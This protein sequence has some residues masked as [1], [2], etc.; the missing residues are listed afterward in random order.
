MCP[1]SPLPAL[2]CLSLLLPAWAAS[3]VIATGWT[4]SA[5]AMRAARPSPSS[6]LL[7]MHV[8]TLRLNPTAARRPPYTMQAPRLRLVPHD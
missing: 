1:Y 5:A 7:K 2:Y 8:R 6:A 4:W 3:Q